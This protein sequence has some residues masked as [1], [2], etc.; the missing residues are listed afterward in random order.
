MSTEKMSVQ[1]HKST[2]GTNNESLYAVENN[3]QRAEN[4][5]IERELVVMFG[6][7]K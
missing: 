3:D 5:P 1:L 4:C 6:G 7:S 2:H